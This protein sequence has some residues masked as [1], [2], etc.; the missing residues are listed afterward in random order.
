MSEGCPKGS[1]NIHWFQL[2]NALTI[3][4]VLGAPLIL[5]AQSIGASSTVLGVLASFT[6][7]T[8]VLQLPA[9]K[10]LPIYGYR[11]FVLMGWAPRTALIFVIALIPLL[12]FLDST[13]K[14]VMMVAALFVFNILRGA[15]SA[16][17]MPWIAALIPEE[18]RSRFLARDQVFM[19]WGSL[20]A[21]LASAFFMRGEVASWAYAFVFLLSGT[22]GAI[23]LL[24][25]N[26]IP[27]VRAEDEIRH[28]AQ[29]VPW[30]AIL[31]YPPFLSLLIFNVFFVVV[32]GSLGV[33]TIEFLHEFPSFDAE[34]ILYL[35]GVSFA[36]SLAVLPFTGR[37]LERVG[38]KPV[39][40]GALI[41]IST[42]IAGW[43][44]IASRVWECTW[45]IVAVLNFC[46]GAAGAAFNVANGRIAFATMP[47][48]GR[49]HFFALFTVITSLG[50]GAAPVVW[51][52]SL[53]FIGT[54][55]VVTGE[56]HWKRHS[57]YFATL[58]LLN[59]LTIFQTRCLHENPNN[60]AGA[61][62]PAGSSE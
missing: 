5:Y 7:L 26:K 55:E 52:I 25:I 16:A 19:F 59:L 31:F 45:S 38:I 24:F 57:I 41:L 20:L 51:G 10:L 58:F 49:N 36:G 35:T 56:F 43:C 32:V 30:R 42:V 4:I 50:L 28:A 13:S 12:S 40:C 29:S 54:F 1:F 34:R 48:M 22:A 17:W 18:A 27:D 8:T 61:S 14:L 53:D 2:F 23:G 44:L 47:R 46:G 60:D 6:P 11:R 62:L 9:S 3:Q 39:L 37:L 33:F 21:L 15:A